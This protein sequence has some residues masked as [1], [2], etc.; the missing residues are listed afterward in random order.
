MT[1]RQKALDKYEKNKRKQAMKMEERNLD[2]QE[3]TQRCQIKREED[4]KEI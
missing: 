1:N 2:K 4:I 3:M